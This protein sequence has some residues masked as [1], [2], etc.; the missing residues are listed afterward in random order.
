MKFFFQVL[1]FLLIVAAVI[2]GYLG[3]VPGFSSFLGSDKPRNLGIIYSDTDR[4][5]AERILGMEFKSLPA[6]TPD[7]ESLVYSGKKEGQFSLSEVQITALSNRDAKAWKDYPLTQTQVKIGGDGTVE[8]SGILV[9]D[10]LAG[11]LIQR[12]FNPDDAKVLIDRLSFVK[13][14][15]PVYLKGKGEVKDN[16]VSA[17]IK[18][19]EVGRIPIPFSILSS[20]KDRILTFIKQDIIGK[21]PELQIK[22]LKFE[23]GKAI[24]DGSYPETEAAVP[25]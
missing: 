20:N 17:D 23:D 8:I 10:R 3:I 15:P 1:L 2:I 5:E 13:V 25:R 7:S 4:V 22:T 14:N 11:F 12:G 6:E 24:F 19:I 21:I 16:E 9:L 18:A